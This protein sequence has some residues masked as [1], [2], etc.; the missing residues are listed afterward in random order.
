MKSFLSTVLVLITI[1]LVGCGRVVPPGMTV[2]VVSTDGGTQ[3]HTDGVYKAVGRDRAYFIDSRLAS[4]TESL[5]ILCA[6]DVNMSVQ[7][8]WIGSFLV[9]KRTIPVIKTKV[10]AKKVERD[11][12]SGF[13][14][15]LKAFYQTA[16]ADIIRSTTRAIVGQYKTDFIRPNRSKIQMEIKKRVLAKLDKLNYPVQTSDIMISNLDYDKVIT[17][18][19]QAIK[20]AEL[21]DKLK[22]AQAKA[23]I[24]Q[25]RRDAE[26]EMEKGKAALVAAKAKARVNEIISR[27]ITKKVLMMK[28]YEVMEKMASGPNNQTIIMPYEA[29]H[30]SLD[31]VLTSKLL[32]K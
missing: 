2:M 18:Q 12:I 29:L 16:I 13:E 5:N 10:P 28:Q 20:K 9:N 30:N 23:K 14:L 25:Y 19:R 4:Y 8:K 32:K 1:I 26:I 17:M 27:S 31:S 15:S 22:A 11:D 24:A 21:D 6:D 3:I 7:V